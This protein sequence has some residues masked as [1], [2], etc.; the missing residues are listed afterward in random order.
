MVELSVVIPTLGR[1]E[2]LRRA[3]AALEAQTAAP[4]AF[5][6]VVV[7]DGGAA[8]TEAIA[9]ALGDRPFATRQR[10][11]A[12]PGASSARNAGWRDAR[13]PAV[14]FLGDDILAAPDLLE[15]HLRVHRAHP[16]PEVALL[17]HVRWAG[18]LDVTPFM[19]W[20]ERGAQFEYHALA[21]DKAT[22]S[23]FYTA[24]VSVKRDLLERAGG[25]DEERFPF[26]YEDLDMGRR[27]ADRGMRLRYDRDAVGEH[28]HRT[29]LAEWE[30]R[31]AAVARSERRWVEL[32]PEEPAFFHRRVTEAAATRR[33]PEWLGA[34][35]LRVPRGVPAAGPLAWRVADQVWYQRLAPAFLRGWEE[36]G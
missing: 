24:N 19:R 13:A 4:E 8:A 35:A 22:W 36:A 14:L 9:A 30:R 15:R 17:G 11:G 1:T 26:L 32:H 18:E 23:H 33:L 31:M 34:L 3:L 2:S 5:E 12:V 28:L 10:R 16:E 20:L 27:L 25:F 21:G 7:E 29:T 6:V